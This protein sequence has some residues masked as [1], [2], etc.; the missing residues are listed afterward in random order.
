MAIHTFNCDPKAAIETAYPKVISA[1]NQSAGTLIVD[2]PEDDLDNRIIMDIVKLIRSSKSRRQLVF[3]TH[4]PNVVVNGDAD[5]I[6]ALRSSTPGEANTAIS[7]I[8]IDVD[9]SIETPEVRRAITH[10][11]EGGR[12][13]FDL[14]GRKYNFDGLI[15]E[16][17]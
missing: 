8:E 14:R 2:Q 16:I 1:V 12:A 13:A 10:V 6:I 7:Q 5:K 9:G 17:A 15:T 11:M 3:S 4:N